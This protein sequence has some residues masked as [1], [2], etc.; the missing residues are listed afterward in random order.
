MVLFKTANMDHMTLCVVLSAFMLPVFSLK[1]RESVE[2]TTVVN[3]YIPIDKAVANSL[4]PSIGKGGQREYSPEKAL[5]RGSGYWCSEGSHTKEAIVT[6]TGILKSRRTTE[7]VEIHWAYA[8][9]K[10]RI[11]LFVFPMYR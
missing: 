11:F 5:S 8:P 10:G 1:L 6:W 4:F 7:G 2:S 3:T 9:G